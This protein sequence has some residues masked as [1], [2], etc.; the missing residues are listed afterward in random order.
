MFCLSI[1]F[2]WLQAV[3]DTDACIEWMTHGDQVQAEVSLEYKATF[4]QNFI[5]NIFSHD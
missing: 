3:Y 5:S 2:D 4:Y 1:E